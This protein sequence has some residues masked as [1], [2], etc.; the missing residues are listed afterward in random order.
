MGFVAVDTLWPHPQAFRDDEGGQAG[1]NIDATRIRL[2]FL[3]S[4]PK[5]GT[6]D[7]IEFDVGVVTTAEDVKVS[8]QDLQVGNE[9]EPDG[10]IDQFRVVPAAS[11]VTNQWVV[12]GLI[13]SDGTDTG[14]KRAVLRGDGLAF[15]LEWDSTIG[16]VQILLNHL[17]DQ[18]SNGHYGFP[19]FAEEIGGTWSIPTGTRTPLFAL[20]Y[21]DGSYGR[22]D[23]CFPYTTAV[24]VT[25]FDSGSSPDEIGLKFSLPLT[26]KAKGIWV[27]TET[28]GEQFDVV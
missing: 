6:I 23:G 4:V 21:A 13:T 22:V 11:I 9:G 3:F 14:A 5:D 10:V 24:L 1:R 25:D 18:G 16:D 19:A 15:V 28:S 17:A 26:V 27:R 20:K 12:P 8:L 7:T 2:A